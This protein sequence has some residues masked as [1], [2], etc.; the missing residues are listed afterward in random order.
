MLKRFFK[1]SLIYGSAN[2]F[3]KGIVFLLIPIYTHAFL[4]R[5]FGVLDFLTA[6]GAIV[7]VVLPLG[8][9]N[10][11][12]RYLPEA[13]TS[14]ESAEFASSAL[15]FTLATYAVFAI[16]AVL[17]SDCITVFLLD[18]REFK[19]LFLF[20]VAAIVCNGVLYSLQNLLRW[21]LLS[22]KF[23]ISSF[24]STVLTAATAV[25]FILVL[26]TGVIGVFY[27]QIVGALLGILVTWSY[28]RRALRLTFD[29]QKLKKMIL[30]GLPVV[31][32][33][34]GE[35]FS[36]Y[37]D[38]FA[39]KNFLSMSDV[40]IYGV[41]FRFASIVNLLL[42]GFAS[43]LTPLVYAHYKSETA[44][45]ELAQIF[46]YFLAMAIP[47]IIAI[48]LFSREVLWIF[49]T[50]GYYSAWTV[51]PI[52]STAYLLLA[53]YNFAPGLHITM[54]TK[55]IAIIHVLTAILNTVLNFTL[56][57]SMGIMGAALSA[58]LSA[59]FCFA[60]YMFISQR[61]YPIPH[62][63]KRII[64]GASMGFLTSLAAYFLFATESLT[65]FF[66]IFKLFLL[67]ITSLLSIYLIL[68][69]RETK[70]I[71]SR[72]CSKVFKRTSR[73]IPDVNL[74]IADISTSV[75]DSRKG[76]YGQLGDDG[77]EA[78]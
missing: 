78:N 71:I 40:G 27:G 14:A 65:M 11:I 50:P 58:L 54:K 22:K 68:G 43:A 20:A 36:L 28:T 67:L 26:K 10:G 5:D 17:F 29:Y 60:S 52:L 46:S 48:S 21:Q 30:F 9:S 42:T 18:S 70:A 2:F 44:P 76:Y 8:I 23:A 3:A 63:W 13:K 49:T 59:F 32:A 41:G 16:L 31:P 25:F 64:S 75:S 15:W 19:A 6:A 62:N 7:S 61:L 1:D 47:L 45:R 12:A 51:I 37:I 74:S 38:R 35:F 33:M 57:Q 4:P 24:L 77:Q 34:V 72:F 53:M 66:F 69:S 56:V 39:I 73:I 55:T